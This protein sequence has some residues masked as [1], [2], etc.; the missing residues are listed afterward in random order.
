MGRVR[1]PQHQ[2]HQAG[3][4]SLLSQLPSGVPSAPSAGVIGTPQRRIA[5]PKSPKSSPSVSCVPTSVPSP[6]RRNAG[7][8]LVRCAGHS[9][10]VTGRLQGKLVRPSVRHPSSGRGAGPAL[11]S[12]HSSSGKDVEASL[13]GESV[14]NLELHF[15]LWHDKESRIHY[16]ID[17]ERYV[18]QLALDIGSAMSAMEAVGKAFSG[19]ENAWHIPL[20]WAFGANINS[21]LRMRG[22]WKWSDAEKIVKGV[23]L[24]ALTRKRWFFDGGGRSC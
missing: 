23:M 15:R 6:S 7:P 4:G 8:A 13:W 5:P 12:S 19:H 18:Y 11:G 21:K 16:G 3:Y 9:D 24:E 1:A 14:K 10:L 20:M 22:P 2:S 17:H